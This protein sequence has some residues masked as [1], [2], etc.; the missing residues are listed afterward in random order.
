MDCQVNWN[1]RLLLEPEELSVSFAKYVMLSV[2]TL[3]KAHQYHL[4]PLMQMLKLFY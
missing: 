4:L 3:W 2:K 1:K